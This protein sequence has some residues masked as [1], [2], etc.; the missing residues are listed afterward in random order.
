M[1]MLFDGE[2][3]IFL[4]ELLAPVGSW[5]SLVAAVESG[6]NAVY[7]A[8]QMFGARAYASNFDEELLKKAI[9]FAHMRQVRVHVT[10]NTIVGDEEMVQLANYLRFLYEAGADAVLVQDFGVVKLAREVV[11]ELPLHASTQMTVHNLAGVQELERL[12]FSRVVLAR[13]VSLPDIEYICANS[14]AEI[15]VFVHG[16]LCISY[17]GQCLMSSMI[18]GRS[19]NRGRCA[20]PCRLPYTLVDKDDKDVLA[21][22]DA[23]QYLLSPRDL[24]AIDVLPDLIKAGV[25]SLKIEGRMKR[26]EYVATVVDAYRRSVDSCL[27]AALPYQVEMADQKN[28]LQIFNRDFTAAYLTGKP[29]REMM[30]DRRPNNRGVLAGRVVRYD[31]KTKQ[32]T[33]KL[34]EELNIND[35]IDFWV[36]VGGRVT[37]TISE[38]W[39]GGK[40]VS[41]AE[42]NQEVSFAL[43]TPVRDH[44]RAFKVF[45]AAMM[46]RARAFFNTG[47][48]V[49]RI[50]LAARVE[51]AIGQ[52][53]RIAVMDAD[54]Y[55]GYGE[56]DFIGEKALKRP[57]NEDTVRKQVE[58][59]GTTVY[60]LAELTCDIKGEVMVP[61]SEINEARRKAVEMAMQARLEPFERP[62]LPPTV[63]VRQRYFSCP[64]RSVKTAAALVVHVDTV[65]K[66]K[67]ALAAGAD[68]I[69]FGGE[70]YHHE[71]ITPAMYRE[72][73]EL[74]R[75]AGKKINFNTPRIVR[76]GQW[77]GFKRQLEMFAELRPDQINVH[78]IGGIALA[79][80]ITDISLQADFSLNIYN[81]L[82][83]AFLQEC[84]VDAA[85]LSPEM[86]LAQ[87]EQVAKLSPLP[88]ECIVH[89]NLELM[90][91]EY[92]AMGSFLG[93]L[94][95]GACTQPCT[96]QSYWL[97]DRKEE[98]FPLVTDQYCHMHVLNG[99]ELSMM[100]HVMKFGPLGIDRVRIEGKYMDAN[101]VRKTT[102]I[103]RELLDLGGDHP[104]FRGGEMEKAEGGQITRGHYFRGVL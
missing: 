80:E 11:P 20:Q 77:E 97:K 4:V 67:A 87:V 62:V 63:D 53:L 70:S 31:M 88:L 42:G 50:D 27:A 48:P 22:A 85:V 34:A 32:V 60:H 10:V 28:L 82:A 21:K 45:D 91:S 49:R 55:K 79:R 61:V 74:A 36:K 14:K 81:H 58:R 72:A 66:V 92:C 41:R 19:G 6:A 16:A 37:A 57:L 3:R 30:S 40:K 17:S 86:T 44:D 64:R 83:L 69:L 35:I 15:E 102:K 23:G 76:Q 52:P 94:D 59:L 89:G 33:I 18:G 29:S 96:K 99:K 98:H 71:N 46:D 54:G 47:A 73:G 2:G 101:Q 7:L 25:A 12:G 103:Y 39:V 90:V 1:Y 100:P 93:G 56:T 5:E 68:R 104:L 38:M 95:K 84:G 26:P 43:N 51:A 9:E 24:K 78:N 65:A 13:E 75:E 8:G